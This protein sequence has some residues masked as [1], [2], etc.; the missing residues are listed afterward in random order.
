MAVIQ[1]ERKQDLIIFTIIL[2]YSDNTLGIVQNQLIWF[3]DVFI[4]YKNN[5]QNVSK[6][7]RGPKRKATINSTS[8]YGDDNNN[9]VGRIFASL[10][11]QSLLDC[12]L[13]CFCY[14]YCCIA[15]AVTVAV[16]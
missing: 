6:F 8:A 1:N 13:L 3:L 4:Y 5:T 16:C 7:K 2:Y 10:S 12:Y 11:L 9:V 15:A 14:V